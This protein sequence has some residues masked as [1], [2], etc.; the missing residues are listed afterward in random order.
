MRAKKYQETRSATHKSSIADAARYVVRRDFGTGV[1][2]VGEETAGGP[3]GEFVGTGKGVGA[4]A[5]ATGWRC[6]RG[7]ALA[8]TGATKR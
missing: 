6:A 7:A 3:A 5:G 4:L 1:V 2:G 8:E